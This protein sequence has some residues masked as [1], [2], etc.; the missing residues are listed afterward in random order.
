[1]AHDSALFKKTHFH[2]SKERNTKKGETPADDIRSFTA[3]GVLGVMHCEYCY[4]LGV[5]IVQYCYLTNLM[6]H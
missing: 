3:I 1:M 5:A 4:F 2:I 6:F